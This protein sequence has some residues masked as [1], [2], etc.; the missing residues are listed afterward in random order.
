MSI[1]TTG[2]PQ[3]SILCLLLLLIYINDLYA[4]LEDFT[5]HELDINI[6]FEKLTSWFKMNKLSLNVEKTKNMIFRKRK[7]INSINININGIKTLETNHF[8]FL[9]IV[10]NT[11]LTWMIHLSTLVEKVSKIVHVIR[12]FQYIYTESIL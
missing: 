9:G 2:V 7:K 5:S 1:I 12:C 4:N 11:R 8:N 6:S 3:G 10:F